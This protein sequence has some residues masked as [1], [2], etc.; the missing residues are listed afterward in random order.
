MLLYFL[1]HADSANS[2]YANDFD[3]E[4][5]EEGRAQANDVAQTIRA[6]KLVFT[7]VLSSPLI[8]ARQ[9]AKIAI[10]NFSTLEIQDCD[11]LS[12]LSEPRNLFGEL[13]QY[14]QDS[15]ILLVTHEPFASSCIA[16][17]ISGAN[18]SKVAMKKASMAC[19]ETHSSVQRGT[20]I[21]LWLLTNEQM[22]LLFH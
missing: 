2:G 17:L 21:L 18:E 15:R 1:R 19:L 10:S 7:H 5:T 14:P 12:P 20:G 6:L 8:R 4:L 11:Y 16:S 3:R 13:A 22:R 9:T